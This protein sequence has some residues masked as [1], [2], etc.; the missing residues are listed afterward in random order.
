MLVATLSWSTFGYADTLYKSNADGTRLDV[1]TTAG[2][3]TI[4][5]YGEGVAPGAAD[6]I[7]FNNLI[8]GARTLDVSQTASTN[9]S[10]AGLLVLDP[11]GLI[12]IRNENGQNQTLTIGAS[13]INMSA[14]TQSLTLSSDTTTAGFALSVVLGAP[15]TWSVRDGRTLTVSTAVNTGPNALTIQGGTSGAGTVLLSGNVTGGGAL[16]ISGMPTGAGNAVTLSGTA[17]ALGATT[18]AGGS[19]LTIDQTVAGNR[20]ADASTLTLNRGSITLSGTVGGTEAVGGVILGAGTNTITGAATRI[21][22]MGAITRGTGAVL[23]T[24]TAASATTTTPNVNGILGGWAVINNSDFSTNAFAAVATTTTAETGWTGGG[25]NE[26]QTANVTLTANRD[27]NSLKL[28]GAA[29]Q[30][31]T[32]TGFT[33]N[34]TSGGILRNQN[35]ATTFTGGTLTSG[36]ADGTPDELFIWNNQSTMTIG[37]VIANNGADVLN[38]TKAGGHAHPHGG[39]HLRWRYHDRCWNCQFR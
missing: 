6:I 36:A 37:S 16:S 7:A 30:T 19:T 24:A 8:N 1:A 35:F 26:S 32:L 3:N 28:L 17:N 27:I 38:L 39:K 34:L 10:V 20:L 22:G 12:T 2:F 4:V 14:A 18:V 25:L 31:I 23:N 5:N 11:G 33:L 21:L 9:L 29:A 13:G 15:Q